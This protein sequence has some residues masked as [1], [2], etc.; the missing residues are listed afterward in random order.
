MDCGGLP[1]ER[2]VTSVDVVVGT[3][4]M[5]LVSVGTGEDQQTVGPGG[6]GRG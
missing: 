2:G 5:G 1:N 6:W 4:H 3:K